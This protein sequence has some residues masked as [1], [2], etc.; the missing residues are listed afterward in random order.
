MWFTKIK[1]WRQSG[2][3]RKYYSVVIFCLF[4]ISLY[5]FISTAWISEDAFITFRVVDNLATGRGMVW[6]TDERVQAFTHPLWMVVLT[7]I[8]LITG[9]LFYTAIALSGVYFLVALGVLLNL[10]WRRPA[11]QIFLLG[12]ML[13]SRSFTDYSTSGLENPLLHVMMLFFLYI[14]FNLSNQ[15]RFI[16]LL[17]LLVSLIGLTRQDAL[18]LVLP[19]WFHVCWQAGI[20]KKMGEITLGLMPLVSWE[21]F[22]L[23]YY[24][25]FVPNTALAKITGTIPY[26]IILE[27]GI[28]YIWY[29]TRTDPVTILILLAAAGIGIARKYYLLL[30]GVFLYLGYVVGIGGDFMAGRFLSTPFILSLGLLG[31]T[32]Q[33]M[34]KKTI[35][36]GCLIL[37]V[38]AF[39]TENHPLFNTRNYSNREF[40][41]GVADERGYYYQTH[42]LLTAPRDKGIPQYKAHTQQRI[43]TSVEIHANIG[44]I[45]FNAGP[46]VHIVDPL[47]LADPLLARLAP[48]SGQTFRPGHLER[49]IPKGYIES[50]QTGQ[51]MIEDPG[52]A[53]YYEKLKLITRGQ[54]LDEQRLRA[55]WGLHTGN[56]DQD[57][58]EYN[59]LTQL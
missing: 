11:A 8:Y 23:F 27:H 36:F 12:A 50:I 7:S 5:V 1:T 17:T 14:Y 31:F 46:Q 32:S 47:A 34:S 38:A 58:D 25:S 18:L 30:L 28:Y 44:S 19:L 42:G 53:R 37:I 10:C 22:S 9:E 3:F 15:S 35:V 4:L 45:G 57:I 48:H 59:R 55:I 40:D 52:V 39:L 6:N 2:D 26:Q 56:Y 33:W 21:I 43:K 29:S 51:N 20:W 49:R 54:L 24:G 13:S 16:F 41:K